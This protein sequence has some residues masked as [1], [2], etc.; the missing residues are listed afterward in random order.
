MTSNS[1]SDPGGV[2]KAQCLSLMHEAQRYFQLLNHTSGSTANLNF[3]LILFAI[4]HLLLS[5]WTLR[6]RKKKARNMKFVFFFNHFYFNHFNLFPCM[7][8]G[9]EL[10]TLPID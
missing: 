3:F 2:A 5:P 1:V 9:V 10:N 6:K 7:C 8:G 4:F